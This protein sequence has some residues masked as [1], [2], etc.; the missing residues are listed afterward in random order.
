MQSIPDALSSM[1][2]SFPPRAPERVPLSLALGRHLSESLRARACLPPFSNSAMDGYAVRCA[3]L[4]G[5]SE[6]TPVRRPCRGESRAGG[7]LP[8]RLEPGCVMRIFT[9]A[10]L[11][12]GADA[13]VAQEDTA[14]VGDALELRVCPSPGRH[15]RA[16]ASDL[17]VGDPLLPAG[18][19]V[20]SGEIALL[21]SQEWASV[22]VHRRPSVAILSTGDELRDV[23]DPERPGSLLDSNAPMLAAAV[24]EAGGVPRVLPRAPD[25]ADAIEESLRQALEA[26]VVLTTGGVS[27]GEYDLLHHVFERVGVETRFWKIAIKPGKPVRFGV[28]GG[29]PVVGLPGNPVSAWVTFRIFVAP[30]LARMA[31]SLTPH[32]GPLAVTLGHA[33]E[34]RPGRTELSRARLTRSPEGYVAHLHALQGSGSMPSMAAVDALVVLPAERGSFRQGEALWALP[35]GELPG[36]ATSFFDAS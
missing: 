36:Q 2:A 26:D 8:G 33:H 4:E 27:V 5:A 10:P 14:R 31:G 17:E 7:D 19:R 32:P 20:G 16:R 34:R 9:G 12:E 23:G 30:G 21:A 29:V 35:V 11:P 1:L 24:R 22:N 28:A 6:R 15:V 25:D 18:A 13:V 3:E